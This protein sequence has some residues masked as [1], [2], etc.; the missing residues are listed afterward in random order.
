MLYQSIE[1]LL[2]P[3][4][5]RYDQAIAIAAV[6]LVVNLVCAWWL[7][8]GHHHH[9]HHDHDHGHP[10]A[11]GHHDHHGDDLNLRAAY[12]HVLADAA[13]SI[14]AIVAL[15]GGRQWG[16]NWLDP[17]MGIVGAALITIWACGLLR[18]TGRVLLDAEMDAPVVA[19]IREVVANCGIEARITD[20]HVWRVGQGRYACILGIVTSA[21]AT[22]SFFRQQLQVHEELAHVTVEINRFAR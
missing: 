3:V 14:L 7:K 1:R 10:H 18:D 12:L 6:G 22:P 5:I 19:E 20:L 13:T 15:F 9:H 2:S 17:M 11:D 4:A 16:A 21:D 8:D